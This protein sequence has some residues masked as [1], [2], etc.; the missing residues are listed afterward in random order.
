MERIIRRACGELPPPHP[1]LRKAR[2]ARQ[3]KATL[4]P[5]G[6]EGAHRKRKT[7][8]S[9][10]HAAGDGVL[11]LASQ[12]AAHAALLRLVGF[13]FA[14][15]RACGFATRRRAG[16]LPASSRALPELPCQT[17]SSFKP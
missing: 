17:S 11:L 6:G 2:F 8:L 13:G 4:S 15:R 16:K 12:D 5:K 14:R 1:A 9:S 10:A 7:A 3:R